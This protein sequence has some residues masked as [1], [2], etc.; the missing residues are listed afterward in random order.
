MTGAIYRFDSLAI[1]QMYLLLV[2]AQKN[3]PLYDSG[4]RGKEYLNA[5]DTA[6][7]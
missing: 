7:L 5:R 3:C 1:C 6:S 4:F 2:L